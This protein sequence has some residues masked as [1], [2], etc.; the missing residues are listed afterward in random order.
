MMYQ[1]SEKKLQEKRS[2]PSTQS[3]PK[4]DK[5]TKEEVVR[6]SKVVFKTSNPPSLDLEQNLPDRCDFLLFYSDY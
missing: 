1:S 4:N 3:V 5:N 6:K 2:R